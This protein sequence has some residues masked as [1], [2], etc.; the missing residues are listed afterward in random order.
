M[1][2]QEVIDQ[3]S[4]YIFQSVTHK[5]EIESNKLEFKSKW[6]DLKTDQVF[7]CARHISGIANSLGGG[8]GFLVFGYYPKEQKFIPSKLSDSGLK[9]PSEI[10]GSINKRINDSISFEIVDFIYENEHPISI[11]HIQ[12]SITKPHILPFYKDKD[13]KEF[14]HVTF[15]R[16]GTR[17]DL[18]TKEDFERMYMDRTNIFIDH[19]V[20]VSINSRTFELLMSSTDNSSW[21]ILTFTAN[22]HF[23]NLGTRPLALSR[24][25][26]D[27]KELSEETNLPILHEVIVF[28][29]YLEL[30]LD[31]AKTTS[32]ILNPKQILERRIIFGAVVRYEGIFSNFRE[33]NSELKDACK[34]LQLGN[35]RLFLN[36][37]KEIVPE[38]FIV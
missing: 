38:V 7:Q 16:N 9:D 29:R 8:S 19:K 23:E 37:G 6:F 28:D 21:K 30:D 10:H 22:F 36:N 18:A 26:V 14:R 31:G 25:I 17:T 12:P 3:I 35:I 5:S 33:V 32:F 11:I 4:R 13:G 24:V 27:T 20:S 34:Y 1:S 15:I 2:H